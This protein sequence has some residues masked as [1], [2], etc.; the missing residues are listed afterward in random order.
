MQ[1]LLEIAENAKA[2]TPQ[3]VKRD[4]FAFIK[5][6][7]EELAAYNRATLNQDSEDVEGKPIGFYSAATELITN[8]RKKRGEP[9]DLLESGDFL[10]GLFAKVQGDSIFFDT[11]DSKR[12]EVL[13]NLLSENIFGMQ[14]EDLNKVIEQRLAPF[15][16]DYYTRKI[17]E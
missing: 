3:R 4:L 12:K 8:G 2:L 6:L 14:E 11:T 1:R 9:F 17:L 16:I 15:F 10:D 7:E 13:K 5:T